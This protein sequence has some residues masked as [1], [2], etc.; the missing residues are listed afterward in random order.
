[1][2][3]A[4]ALV[5]RLALAGLVL[6]CTAL[7]PPARAAEECFI[8]AEAKTGRV[9]AKQ[10]LCAARHSP[11]STFDIPLALIGFDA[12]I[13]KSE[14]EPQI[15]PPAGVAGGAVT[16][17]QWITQQ[18]DWYGQAVA[19]QLGAE[20]LAGTLKA[21]AYGNENLAG[22][23]ARQEDFT[24]S[25]L[26]ASLAIS[27]REQVDFLRR[28][29]NGTLPVSADAVGRTATLLR[30]PETPAGFELYGTKGTGYLRLADAALDRTRP[31][32]W[33]MGWVEK[34]PE[35][36]VFVRFMSMD[37]PASEP[38]GERARRQTLSSLGAIL[39]AQA[40]GR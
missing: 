36:Y 6:A 39:Q 3:R 33:F 25:W 23:P 13:L 32:G 31:L 16:P 20:R 1:M 24:Y 17:R 37:V 14:R 38:L 2:S 9:V 28:M 30:Q 7:A 12:G 40:A 10:G 21:F 19:R 11:A 27:P 8:V 29:L 35:T 22:D 34:G 15:S 4:A 5:R 26:S 18:V